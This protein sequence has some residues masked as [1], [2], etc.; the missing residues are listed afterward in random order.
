MRWATASYA[1]LLLTRLILLD[2]LDSNLYLFIFFSLVVTCETADIVIR[3]KQSCAHCSL[4]FYLAPCYL[5][6]QFFSIVSATMV[7]QSP[8]SP[9]RTRAQTASP[10]L[11]SVRTEWKKRSSMRRYTEDCGCPARARLG[12]V[13]FCRCGDNCVARLSLSFCDQSSHSCN[14]TEEL[15]GRRAVRTAPDGLRGLGLIAAKSLVCGA[16]LDTYR[17]RIVTASLDAAVRGVNVVRLGGGCYVLGKHGSSKAQY[18]NHSCDPSAKLEKWLGADGKSIILRL[19]AR[20]DLRV[21]RKVTID[22]KWTKEEME[23]ISSSGCLCGS[24]LC[25]YK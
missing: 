2:P 15:R 13:P 10:L 25:R 6:R 24:A 12:R 4:R 22:Y 5:I 3:F 16:H 20:R 17:G 1:R 18:A 14:N 21:G 7:S 11:R 8:P 9:R 19:V 23:A